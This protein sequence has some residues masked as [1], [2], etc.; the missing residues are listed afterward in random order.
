MA[1]LISSAQWDN[2]R[3]AIN[4][5]SATFGAQPIIWNAVT[6]RLAFSGDER[7]ADG[8]SQITLMGYCQYNVYKLWPGQRETVSGEIDKESVAIILNKAY[9]RGLNYLNSDGNF[10]FNPDTDTFTINGEI[11]YPAGNTQAAQA[12]DSPLEIYI[13]L[14]RTPVKTGHTPY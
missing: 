9:L 4:N 13:I 3:Q 14:K 6:K 7:N 10:D 8:I 2:F 12:Y 11:Y 5:A 1:E